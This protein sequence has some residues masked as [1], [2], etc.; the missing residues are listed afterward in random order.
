MRIVQ[1]IRAITEAIQRREQVGIRPTSMQTYDQIS[2][3]YL[4][5]LLSIEKWTSKSV[6]QWRLVPFNK[7]AESLSSPFN[8]LESKR[9]NLYKELPV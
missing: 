5:N 8:L 6:P 1:L 4:A 2:F 3:S 9:I 7:Y